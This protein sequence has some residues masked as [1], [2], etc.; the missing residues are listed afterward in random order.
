MERLRV[1]DILDIVHR[2]RS[3]QSER[4]IVRDTGF[5]R[6]TIRDYHKLARRHG[7]LDHDKELPEPAVVLKAL[8]EAPRPPQSTSSVEPYRAVVE[9]LLSAGVEM[10]AIHQRLVEDHG[11]TG[12]YSSIRRFAAKLR[13]KE[14]KAFVRIETPPGQEAQVD[15]GSVGKMRDP[16]SG[17]DRP[18]FCFVMTLSHSRHQYV[19]FVFDQK[20]ETWIGCHRRAFESFGGVPRELVI[21]NLKAAVIRADIL[22]PVL[23]EPY[24][25]M[26]RHY[27]V[28]IHPCRVRTPEHKGKV[29]SG[30]RY[31]QRNFLAGRSFLDIDE[32]N[33]KAMDW[34]ERTAGVR[35][36]GTTHQPPLARFREVEQPAL[37]PLPEEP[38]DLLEVKEVKVHPDCHVQIGRAY[39]SVPFEHVGKR[40]EAHVYERI[41]QLYDGIRLVVTHP[42]ATRP[43]QRITRNEHYP[44]EKMIYLERTPDFCRRKAETVGPHC[45]EVVERLLSERPLD[46]L[47]AVQGIIGLI[48]RFGRERLEAACQ[49]ALHFGDPRY[50]RIRDILKAGLDTEPVMASQS[51]PVPRNYAFARRGSEFA[52]ASSAQAFVEEGVAAC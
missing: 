49:R 35:D 4:G 37:I 7:F 20:M 1:T 23:S 33:L 47:R 51:K 11:Y 13:P 10:V 25:R 50:R 15:F 44:K 32:A 36:H 5:A 30:V 45:A 21:D 6:N 40:L 3:G 18:A 29:E 48:D 2:L 43:G 46:H 22:D 26:A 8:G 28:L 14:T 52:S 39:Y 12:S 9:S 16:K 24:R 42:K 34:V 38:F 27:G 41:V 31:V 19:E 17:K